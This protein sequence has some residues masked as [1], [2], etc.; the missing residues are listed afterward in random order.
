MAL[1]LKKEDRPG[2]LST[3]T[4]TTFNL[5]LYSPEIWSTTGPY[6]RQGPHQVA[7]KSTKTGTWEDI[8][9]FWKES[10][11]TSATAAESPC[12][13]QADRTAPNKRVKTSTAFRIWDRMDN[14][15]DIRLGVV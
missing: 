14:P 5:P 12:L 9:S 1:I 13:A 15:L 10:S 2:F 11:V 6:M 7:Q 4:R 3:S 8:T